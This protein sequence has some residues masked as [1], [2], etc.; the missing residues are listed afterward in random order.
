MVINQRNQAM[1][2]LK[3]LSEQLKLLA[4]NGIYGSCL[5][6]SDSLRELAKIAD[7]VSR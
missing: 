4:D 5:D 6:T 7:N 1:E 2:A 3:F